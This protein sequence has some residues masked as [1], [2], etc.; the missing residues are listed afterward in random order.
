M[1]RISVKDIGLQPYTSTWKEQERLRDDRREGRIG[2][3]V[4]L[5]EH[6]AVFT[7]GRQDCSGDILS[8]REEIERDGIEIVECNRGGRITY[9]GPGQLV[10]YFICKISDFSAGVKDFVARVED[11]GLDLMAGLGLNPLRNRDYPGIWIGSRKIAA[12]GLHISRGISAHGMSINVDPDLSHYRHI[13]PCGIRGLG[14]TSLARELGTVSPPMK[15]VKT[16]LT[17]SVSKVLDIKI[18]YAAENVRSS[19]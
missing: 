9:H 10:A 14:I 5:C 3:V 2:D 19:G 1:K 7:L 13:I 4:V 11:I 17:D 8:P 15:D 18:D 6:P 12:I 16:R